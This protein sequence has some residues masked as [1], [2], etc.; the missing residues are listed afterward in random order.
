MP[1]KIQFTADEIVTAA[2]ALARENGWDGLS[3]KGVAKKIGSSTMPIYSYFDNLEKLKDAVAIKGWYLLMEYETKQ[4]TGDVW[5]DQSMGYITFAMEENNLFH[6]MF[7]GRNNDLQLKMRIIHW[8]RL[9]KALTDYNDFKGLES[10][11]RFL[12]RYSRGM[13]THGLATSVISN[14][15]KLLEIDGMVEN[16]VVAMSRSVLEGYR[17]TYD[18]EN[19]NIA[20][21]DRHLKDLFNQGKLEQDHGKK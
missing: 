20:F 16:L 18:C 9:T 17:T 6:C 2:Y 21:I 15:G 7:D 10:E 8:D 3:V 13:F 1:R 12:I 19:K 11:Q 4:Y 14:W 5:V